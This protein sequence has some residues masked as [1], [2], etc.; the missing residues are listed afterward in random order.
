[1]LSVEGPNSWNISNKIRKVCQSNEKEK[2]KTL[3]PDIS[4][5]ANIEE[6][7]HVTSPIIS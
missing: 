6:T 1:M 3:S 4:T 7:L 5:K 2:K